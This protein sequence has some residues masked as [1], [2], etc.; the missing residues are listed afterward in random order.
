M[1]H[2]IMPR[3]REAQVMEAPV[4]LLPLPRPLMTSEVLDAAFR[5]FRAGILRSLP[6]SILLV[7]LLRLPAIYHLFIDPSSF[8]EFAAFFDLSPTQ[9]GY[10]I[11]TLLVVPLLGVLTLR[12]D[13]LARGQ[14]PRFRPEIGTAVLRWPAALIATFGAFFIPV[15][16]VL[17]GPAF[18]NGLSSEAIL[19]LSIPL[20]WPTAL[21]VVA[22]PAYWCEPLGPFEAIVK[23]VVISARKSWRMVGAI[24]AAISVIGVF[25]FVAAVIVGL[26]APL[27]M[28]ADLFLFATLESL[29]FV[30]VGA[31]GVPFL[32]AVFIVAHRDL[33]LRHRERRGEKA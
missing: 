6:Y 13:A 1:E 11:A 5:L 20:F 2:G 7:L 27:L 22:L 25:Y 32:L 23:S 24:L 17:L 16:L 28:S 10:A 12:L 19:F 30:I 4:G 21:F 18:S 33:E 29:V 15:S 26:S 14:R 8:S 3:M 9:L 31:F